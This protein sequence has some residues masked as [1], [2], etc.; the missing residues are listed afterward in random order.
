[1]LL[2]LVFTVISFGTEA[3]SFSLAEAREPS[4]AV[5]FVSGQKREL[6]C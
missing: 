5:I 2:S 3:A 6:G 4:A 1:V